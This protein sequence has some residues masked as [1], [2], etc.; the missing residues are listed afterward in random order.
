MM[1]ERLLDIT[2]DI[3]NSDCEEWFVNRYGSP[4]VA[5]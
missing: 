4:V 2:V 1:E 5:L 3:V